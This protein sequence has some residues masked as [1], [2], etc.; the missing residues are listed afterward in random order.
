M[1][2]KLRCIKKKNALSYTVLLGATASD[3]AS[4]QYIAPYAGATIGE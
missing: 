3:P 1:K 4:L 2:I